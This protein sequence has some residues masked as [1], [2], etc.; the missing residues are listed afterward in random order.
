MRAMRSQH[1]V[2]G[3][4]A[5]MDFLWIDT[6]AEFENLRDEAEQPIGSDS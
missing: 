2:T 5:K 1:E 6:R 3:N 4:A